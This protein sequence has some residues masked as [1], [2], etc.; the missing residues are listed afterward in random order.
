MQFSSGAQFNFFRVKSQN[1]SGLKT[2]NSVWSTIYV[3]R[4]NSHNSS[5]Y[6]F[7]VNSHSI[8]VCNTVY[9][10]RFNSNNTSGPSCSK[11]TML[12]VNVLLKFQML[13]SEICQYFLLKN[14]TNVCTAKASHIFSTK[15]TC[16]FGY[17][18]VKHLRN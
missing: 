5:V 18:V 1:N 2:F 14:V 7:R 13:I 9:F 3:S 17:K 12:L 6:F 8:K 15:T 11:L 10:S 4:F 16:V